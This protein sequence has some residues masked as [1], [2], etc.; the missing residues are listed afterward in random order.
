[1]PFMGLGVHILI[2]LLFA[3]HAVRTRQQL[4]WLLILYSFPLLGSVVYFFAIYLPDSRLEY[5]ARKAVAVAARSLDPGREL[6]EA[7]AA[8]DYTPTAQNQMRLAK[9]Q[10]EAGAASAAAATYEA[11][12]NGAFSADLEIRLGAARA[13]LTC[14]RVR[15]AIGHLEFIMKANAGF[16]AEE[17]ALLYAQALGASGRKDDAKTAFE[18]ALARFGSFAVRAEYAIWAA[19]AGEMQVASHLRTEL[20]GMMKH[21]NRHTRDINS[22]LIRRLNAA[23]GA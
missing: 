19:S 7:Q 12:L 1:M 5:G 16:Q 23:F 21:W 13:S 11:C 17:V 9:A 22:T 6:R 3:V 10:L 15:E 20:Q 2:A 8:F 4:Y 14:G 18:D